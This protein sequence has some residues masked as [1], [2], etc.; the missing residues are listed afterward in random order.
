[1]AKFYHNSWGFISYMESDH[2]LAHHTGWLSLGY[3]RTL[4]CVPFCLLGRLLHA[5]HTIWDPQKEG[6][7][8][9]LVRTIRGE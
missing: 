5:E 9:A 3:A 2:S 4:T 8:Y 1:M 7:T 6:L